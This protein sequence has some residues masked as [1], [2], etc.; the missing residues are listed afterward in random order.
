MSSSMKDSALVSEAKEAIEE[1]GIA[2]AQAVEAVGGEGSDIA[3]ATDESLREAIGWLDDSLGSLPS[4]GKIAKKHRD[5]ANKRRRRDAEMD[6]RFRPITTF[7]ANEG[8]MIQA[9]KRQLTEELERRQEL[10]AQDARAKRV[11]D[12]GAA[13]KGPN[14]TD[15][16]DDIREQETTDETRTIDDVPVDED[17]I[18]QVMLDD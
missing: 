4:I 11:P 2:R 18:Q 15:E 5:E 16:Q 12:G 13:S 6:A 3:E 14:K 9:Q 7:A 8:F 1:I 17:D 10:F